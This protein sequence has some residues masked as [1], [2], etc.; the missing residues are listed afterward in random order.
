M[1]GT[2]F[3]YPFTYLIVYIYQQNAGEYKVLQDKGFV[4]YALAFDH[5]LN[6]YLNALLQQEKLSV[7]LWF[8]ILLF[9]VMRQ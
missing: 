2:P 4:V 6:L 1:Q 3:I 8:R 7:K 5:H 9:I